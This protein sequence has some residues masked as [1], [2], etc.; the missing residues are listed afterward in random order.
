M[1][2]FGQITFFA[3]N[4]SKTVWDV[5]DDLKNVKIA[6]KVCKYRSIFTTFYEF[7][8]HF[9][10]KLVEGGPKLI[11]LYRFSESSI[12]MLWG[13]QNQLRFFCTTKLGLTSLSA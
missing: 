4:R 11:C 3:C 10:K 8:S 13:I 1:D 12:Y 9:E 7:K 6:E 5:F 2:F